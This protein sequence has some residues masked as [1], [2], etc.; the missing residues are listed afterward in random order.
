MRN[1]RKDKKRSLKKR[2]LILCEGAKTEPNYFNGIKH[3]LKIRHKLSAV[4]I[5]VYQPNS[6]NP[7]G[8]VNEAIDKKHK[9]NFRRNPYDAIWLVFDRDFH[10]HIAKV[11]QKARKNKIHIAISNICFEVWILMHFEPV[12]LHKPY[13]RCSNVIR[14]MQRSFV[15]KYH[16]NDKHFDYLKPLT[17]NAI[18]NAKAMQKHYNQPQYAEVH[19]YDLNPYSNVHELVEYLISL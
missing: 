7:D 12:H 5:E 11:Y 9:A 4:D 15:K 16:K 13:Q 8:L 3:D 1:K 19:E 2:I 10:P 18:E 6:Y 14:K 17:Q